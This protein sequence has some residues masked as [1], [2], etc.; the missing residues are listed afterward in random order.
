[1]KG[2]QCCGCKPKK[3]Q[4]LLSRP[5]QAALLH[6]QEWLITFRGLQVLVYNIYQSAQQVLINISLTV[7]KAIACFAHE[8]FIDEDN[9]DGSGYVAE[10]CCRI[11]NQLLVLK[12]HRFPTCIPAFACVCASAV[13]IPQGN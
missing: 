3:C 8:Y 13:L 7:A 11:H 4:T 10:P 12:R 1:M 9:E 5:A 2:T 6:V